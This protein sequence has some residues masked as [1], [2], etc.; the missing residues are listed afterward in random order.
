M[1]MKRPKMILFDYGQTLVN[2]APFDGVKGTEAVMRYCTENKY[3]L[4]AEQ[5]QREA[6]AIN[7]EL[8]RFDP[9]RR[10]LFQVEVPNCMFTAYLYESLGIKISLTSEQVD[11]IFWDA[12]SPGRPTKGAAEF[13]EYLA[14][15]GI[16]TG[17]ISNISYCG[18][19]VEQRIRR[20]FPGHPF[21]FIL[22]TSEYLFRKPNRRIFWLALEKAGLRPGFCSEECPEQHSEDR[23]EQCREDS[24]GEVWY[25]GDQYECDIVGAAGAGLFP[26]WYTGAMDMPYI[27]HE[28]IL[29]VGSW[30]EVRAVLEACED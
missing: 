14:W 24:S 29:T 12:A 11:Q 10:H 8:G 30:E 25:I 23:P 26:V 1:Q 28:E 22:A 5:I 20:L 9:A 27:P 15:Q 18:Q 21:E 6:N 4:T 13:L 16:R 3:H 17:V 7:S 2:E 19:V